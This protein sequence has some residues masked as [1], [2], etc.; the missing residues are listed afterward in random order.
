MEKW[1]EFSLSLSNVEGQLLLN[2]GCDTQNGNEGTSSTMCSQESTMEVGLVQLFR[3]ECLHSAFFAGGGWLSPCSTGRFLDAQRGDQGGGIN[4]GKLKLTHRKWN[5]IYHCQ[6]S[7]F[8][9]LVFW[10]DFRGVLAYRYCYISVRCS[11]IDLS[12][13]SEKITCQTS[14]LSCSTIPLGK[15]GHQRSTWDA[16]KFKIVM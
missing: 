1:D 12:Q 14:S 7:I 10:G 2:S 3:S 8:K 15:T 5:V 11:R 4:R 13:G 16:C 9:V 6:L